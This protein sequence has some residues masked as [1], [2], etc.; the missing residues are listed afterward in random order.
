MRSYAL[1]RLALAV[2]VLFGVTV[3]VFLVIALVPG[4]PAL[5]ILGSYA[6]PESVARLNAE[7]GLDR[8][9]PVRYL[10]WVGNALTGDLGRSYALDRPVLDEVLERLGPTLI[11]AAAALGLSALFGLAAGVAS[12]V[13]QNGWVDRA[14][15]LALLLGVSTP[16]FFLGLL[17]V[18]WLSVGLGWFPT[19]GMGALFG[20]GGIA[21]LLRHLV[22]PAVTLAVVATAI[23][24]RLTRAAMLDVLR[25]DFVRTA[26]AKGVEEDW[27]ISVHALKSALVAVVPVIGLQAG[28]VLGGAVYVETVFQWPGVGRMLVEAIGRRDILLVQ[29]GVL[30]VAALYVA[31]NVVTDLAQ[32][33]LDPR[34]EV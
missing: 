14:I 33:A 26:R 2:P 3:V 1:R 20:G 13:R 25:Q 21:D 15:G 23:L 7:L 17:L 27:V 6:T 30:A 8:S 32:A 5:A 12:A 31:I 18:L 9:L 28:Y 34:I 19:G 4:D 24:G 11:L 29:G 22:L 10:A 16:S